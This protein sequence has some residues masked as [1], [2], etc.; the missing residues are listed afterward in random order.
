[1][2]QSQRPTSGGTGTSVTVIMMTMIVTQGGTVV[3]LSMHHGAGTAMISVIV[4]VVFEVP[5]AS[6][7]IMVPTVISVSLMVARMTVTIAVGR[8]LR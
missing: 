4:M 8:P 3:L 1:M 6:A 2:F 7:A 5:A